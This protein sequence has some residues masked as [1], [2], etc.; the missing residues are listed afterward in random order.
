MPKNILYS[1]L[2]KRQE[3]YIPDYILFL[4]TGKTLR[5]LK[6]YMLINIMQYKERKLLPSDTKK[7]GIIL[8][9]INTEK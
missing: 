8:G 6:L 9:K 5:S 2:Q 1:F 3:T 4:E 7:V